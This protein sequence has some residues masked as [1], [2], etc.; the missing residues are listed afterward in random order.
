M[1][2]DYCRISVV[3]PVFKE[4][5]NIRPFLARLEPILEKIGPYEVIF[6]LDPSPDGTE[7]TILREATRNPSVGLIVFSRRFG[8]PAATMGGIL[9]ARGEWVLVIDVDL[10]DPPELIPDLLSKAET[11]SYDVVTAKRRFR[12]G[13]TAIKRLVSH[14]GYTLINRISEVPIP[15]DTGDFRI[16]NRRVVEELRG[17]SE[18][19]GFLRGLVALVGFSQ[20]ELEYDRDPR[21]AGVGNYNRYLGSLKIGLNGIFGFSVVPLQ[22]MMW[23]GFVVA[24]LSA[25]SIFVVIALRIIQ[26]DR[27]PMGIPTAIVL[28]L[29]LGGVQLASIGIL[30]EYIGRIYDE[31]RRRPMYIVQRAFNVSLRDP[32]GLRSGPEHEHWSLQKKAGH[33]S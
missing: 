22:M 24:G 15:R 4:E 32:R 7:Q 10:Q 8:Q 14:V 27:F 33:D 6:A 20:G 21:H 16:M 29:F 11:E 9:N 18:N 1:P 28:V 2:S 19:H 25:C 12:E 17:L 26:G 13:E 5:E 30:G 3:V 31:V 23:T